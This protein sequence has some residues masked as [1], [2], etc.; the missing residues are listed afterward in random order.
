[1]GR[2]K[3]FSRDEVLKKAIPLFWKQGFADT[4]LQDLEKAT[5][6]N[7]SGLYSEFESK[8]DLFLCSLQHYIE[9]REGKDVLTT[10]PLGWN[11][12]ETFL[13]LAKGCTGQKGC[14]A[15]NSMRE[16]ATLP[17]EANVLVAK[18]FTL[19]KRLL[20][21]NIQAELT[22]TD[23][24]AIADILLTFFAGLCL[25]QNFKTTKSSCVRKIENLMHV[26]RSL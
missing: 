1:M 16:F 26:I 10:E 7:K 4:S 11:N 18:S 13:K 9:T 6:V 14:F 15:I 21:K 8:E 22:K 24:E 23:P 2:P 17:A 20:I 25:E 5:G 19:M 12:V 3:N